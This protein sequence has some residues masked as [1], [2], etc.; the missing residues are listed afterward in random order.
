MIYG[1]TKI[2]KIKH[3]KKL[4]KYWGNILSFVNNDNYAGKVIYMKAGKQ[5]SL[6]YHCNKTETYFLLSGKL[7]VGLRLG[8]AK[9]KSVVLNQGDT[10]T[11]P[12]GLMHIRIALKDSIIIEVST[13]DDNGDSH[14]V[15]E[16]RIYAHKE[17]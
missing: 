10:I 13:K 7:K 8:R 3:P 16:G 4:K 9:N 6:E 2:P 14:L 11:I 17:K 1:I 15:E 12:V 5:S